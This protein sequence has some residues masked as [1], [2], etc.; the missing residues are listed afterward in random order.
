M[1]QAPLNLTNFLNREAISN[2]VP[3]A[4]GGLLSA[5]GIQSA[6]RL[7]PLVA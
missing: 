5:R 1:K 2:S 4:S 7:I 3:G 6:P